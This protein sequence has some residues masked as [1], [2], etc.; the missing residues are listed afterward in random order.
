MISWEFK[1]ADMECPQDR[2]ILDAGPDAVFLYAH[3]DKE[4]CW[5]DSLHGGR[6]WDD[7]EA[8]KIQ[9]AD[10]FLSEVED[11]LILLQTMYAKIHAHTSKGNKDPTKT[12]M[13]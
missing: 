8:A 9:S 7:L 4:G 10:E 3:P 2:W 12:L 1:E 11:S 13:I 6:S 5:T